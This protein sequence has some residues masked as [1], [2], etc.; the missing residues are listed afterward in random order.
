MHEENIHCF[1]IQEWRKPFQ[2]LKNQEV[3]F[4]KGATISPGQNKNA[5]IQI[6]RR[7]LKAHIY[8]TGGNICNNITHTKKVTALI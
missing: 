3:I 8:N 2:W 1:V 7:K 6:R 4:K 5:C